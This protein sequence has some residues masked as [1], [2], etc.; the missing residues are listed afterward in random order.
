M[1]LL[2]TLAL[3]MT[4]VFASSVQ[5]MPDPEAFMVQY[6]T[7]APVVA[8]A[9][10][11]PEATPVPTPV[12]T[13][14]VSPNP[15]YGVLQIGDKGDEVLRLQQTLAEY[16]YYDGDLDSRYGNQTR[17]AVEKFQYNHGLYADGIAGKYTLSVLYDSNQVRYATATPTP[18]PPADNLTVALPMEA[19]PTEAPVTATPVPETPVPETPVPE[20]PVPQTT[21]TPVPP[22]EK[23]P[24]EAMQGWTILL[25][26]TGKQLTAESEKD[27]E[28]VA[29][30]I[31]PYLSG[32]TVYLPLLPVL[33]AGEVLVI[34]S[35]DRLDKLEIGFAMNDHLYRLSFVED[36]E[37]N[38]SGLEIYCD[39]TLMQLPGADIR[40]TNGMYYLPSDC[41]TALTG[42]AANVDGETHT[43]TLCGQSAE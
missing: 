10:A 27:G 29:E 3:Y 8:E 24:F 32:D 15:A 19:V 42:L 39:E 33:E 26:D 11:E 7:P 6:A 28:T 23:A 18:P 34:T 16:G 25:E 35:L 4:M 5:A 1:N 9:T 30:P 2:K 17:M 38:P 21:E 12:P 40:E 14:Q 41:I 13:V 31:L 36:R 22:V 43:I 20:T 37:G